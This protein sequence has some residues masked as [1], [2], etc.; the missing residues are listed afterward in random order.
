MDCECRFQLCEEELRGQADPGWAGTCLELKI[1]T[2]E[3]YANFGATYPQQEFSRA[4][5]AQFRLV[6]VEY[7]V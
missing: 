7:E 3:Y 2:N 6:A 4:G 5:A 1:G